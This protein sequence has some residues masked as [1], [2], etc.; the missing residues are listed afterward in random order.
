MMQCWEENLIVVQLR[1]AGVC[2]MCI[3]SPK[4]GPFQD[5]GP[6][7]HFDRIC[8]GIVIMHRPVRHFDAWLGGK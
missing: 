3:R 8:L 7:R 5:G 1:S 2:L 4:V 6:V